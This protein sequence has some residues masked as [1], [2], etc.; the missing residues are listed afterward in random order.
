LIAKNQLQAFKVTPADLTG[1][2]CGIYY[3]FVKTVKERVPEVKQ[4]WAV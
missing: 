3:A 2:K 4:N 1:R